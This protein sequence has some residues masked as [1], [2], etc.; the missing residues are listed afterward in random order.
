M[1]NAGPTRP[2]VRAETPIGAVVVIVVVPVITLL[3]GLD[4]AVATA[5][6]QLAPPALA[7]PK[8]TR[9]VAILHAF[10]ADTV[11]DVA[12]GRV[13]TTMGV[14]IAFDAGAETIADTLATHGA[15]TRL[16]LLTLALCA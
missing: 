9:A 6:G 11:C 15:R 3:A 8:V 10:G 5:C 12:V 14:G 2:I 7:L 16:D 13:A 1:A 4:P